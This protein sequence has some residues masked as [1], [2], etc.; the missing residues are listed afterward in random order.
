MKEEDLIKMASVSPLNALKECHFRVVCLESGYH[1]KLHRRVAEAYGVAYS[2]IRDLSSWRAFA[3]DDFW[4]TYKKRPKS[5]S[6]KRPLLNVMVYVFHGTSKTAYSRAQKY[7]AALR[8]YFNE[9]VKPEDIEALIARKGGLEAMARAAAAERRVEAERKYE[10]DL[11]RLEEYVKD[12]EPGNDDETGN[13]SQDLDEEQEEDDEAAVEG[14]V[15]DDGQ[16]NEDQDE[17]NQG[18]NDNEQEEEDVGLDYQ[19]ADDGSD[20]PRYRGWKDTKASG[21][22]LYPVTFWVSKKFLSRLA[23][24]RDGNKARIVVV[25]LGDSK[26]IANGSEETIAGQVLSLKPIN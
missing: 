15:E 19:E 24:V 26:K 7:A 6:P 8:H 18:E 22:S 9:G 1:E 11:E 13:P 10:E 21:T 4:E 23:K 3:T 12:V 14:E 20:S 25:R 16:A 17:D 2:L 5:I